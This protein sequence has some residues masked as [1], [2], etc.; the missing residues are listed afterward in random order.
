M[1]QRYR[2]RV[3]AGMEER[4]KGMRKLAKKAL[5]LF[6]AVLIAAMS[7]FAE[8]TI[9]F[10]PRGGSVSPMTRSVE[11][12]AAVGELP[13]PTQDGYTFAGWWTA[14][15]EG[16]Q[17]Y[18]STIVSEDATFY[19]RWE[20]NTYIVT[21]NA[22][23]G[24][25]FP[26]SCSMTRDDETFPTPEKAGYLFLGWFTEADGGDRCNFGLICSNMTCYAH[27][28][29][30]EAAGWQYD[31][32]EDGLV[33][34]GYEGNDG[35]LM[36]HVEIP[37]Q[38]NGAPVI[39]VGSGIFSN[40]GV[41]RVTIPD[42]VRFIG[43]NAFAHCSALT[44]VAIGSG[45][46]YIGDWAF[47]GCMRLASLNIPNGVTHIGVAAFD[48]CDELWTS[49]YRILANISAADIYGG[50]PV[51]VATTVVQQVDAPYS[52]TGSVSDRSIASVIVDAD[53]SID[54]FVL[55]D[56]KVYDAILRIVNTAD[57]EVRL[58]LPM[59]YA[60]ETFKDV[61]PLTIPANS[62][63]LLSITRTADKT[64]LISREELETAQ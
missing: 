4:Q 37:S 3:S 27:W 9:T 58:A 39:G 23:G 51:V 62:R 22:N 32:E 41:T 1:S 38:I 46:R 19:A 43:D 55:K 25:V 11:S 33:L 60:Y 36:G 20:A 15:K 5:V 30:T 47:T 24:S 45:V 63:N 61:R 14:I 44:N 10:D 64:F 42:S 49:W 12:G 28:I 13:T 6:S 8:A 31:N 26:S 18:A 16:A 29:A 2:K 56:G 53:C 35:I 57:H 54:S 40:Q 21:F 59:G 17:I 48:G 50:V 34:N 52:L 7:T